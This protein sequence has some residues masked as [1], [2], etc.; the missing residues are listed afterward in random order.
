MKM[1]ATENM[2]FQRYRNRLRLKVNEKDKRQ[3]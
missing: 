2:G 1:G 3:R